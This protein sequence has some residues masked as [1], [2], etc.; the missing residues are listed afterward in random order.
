VRHHRLTLLLLLFVLFLFLV[1][2]LSTSLSPVLPSYLPSFSH[3]GAHYLT[4]SGLGLVLRRRLCFIGVVCHLSHLFLSCPLTCSLALEDCAV[5]STPTF[6]L[7]LGTH[8]LPVDSSL[9]GD[10]VASRSALCCPLRAVPCQSMCL[11]TVSIGGEH[12]HPCHKGKHLVNTWWMW[13]MPTGE[14]KAL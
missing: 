5:H 14:T 9:S 8:A 3:P 2:L 10:Q 11:Q 13:W 6:W 4:Q 12:L 7:L 1:P